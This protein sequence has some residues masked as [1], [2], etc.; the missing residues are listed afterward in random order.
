MTDLLIEQVNDEASLED[1]R[2]VHNAI[3]PTHPLS[4]DEVRERSGRHRLE[5][6]YLG[7]APVGC[8]TVRPPT[9][10][11]PAATVIARILPAHRNQGFGTELYLRGLD[12]ARALVAAAGSVG[13]ETIETVVLAS[14]TDGLRFAERH[15]FVEVE[16]YVL[17]GD[18]VPYL[19]LRLA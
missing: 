4:L 14:N 18:T 2:Y 13:A 3:I 11:D 12:H 1:W 15:G 16:R 9:A 8:S 5:V 17:E 6:V 19:T 7:D 10:E